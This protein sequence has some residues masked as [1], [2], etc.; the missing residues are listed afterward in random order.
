MV[1]APALAKQVRGLIICLDR[2]RGGRALGYLGKG[3]RATG[4]GCWSSCRRGS[5]G[6]RAG[7]SERGES[8]MLLMSGSALRLGMSRVWDIRGTV[9]SAATPAGVS[10][11]VDILLSGRARAACL[12]MSPTVHTHSYSPAPQS[13]LT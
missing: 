4:R 10:V 2:A 5:Q 9:V 12:G 13:A 1:R 3:V 6:R 11:V 7:V 8:G